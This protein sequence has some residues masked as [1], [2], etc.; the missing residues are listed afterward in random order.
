MAEC[1]EFA[2][3]DMPAC[4]GSFAFDIFH[5][6][7]TGG[8]FYTVF[9]PGLVG[10]RV[11]DV[12]GIARDCGRPVVNGIGCLAF[13]VRLGGVF[14]NECF[15]YGLASAPG[16]EAKEVGSVLAGRML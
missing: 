4:L 3:L 7:D 6:C 12:A 9:I 5:R 10:G 8:V 13:G 2:L 14:L 1:R 11:C 15:G 16:V